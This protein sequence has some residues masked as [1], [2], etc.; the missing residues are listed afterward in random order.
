MQGLLERAEYI[1]AKLKI[2]K[3]GIYDTINSD[4][5]RNQQNVQLSNCYKSIQNQKKSQ[6]GC[7]SE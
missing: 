6:N 2:K 4:R 3:N 7:W 1:S 5:Q